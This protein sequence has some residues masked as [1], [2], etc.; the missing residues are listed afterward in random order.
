LSNEGISKEYSKTI[1]ELL[2]G[3]GLSYQLTKELAAIIDYTNYSNGKVANHLPD[4]K[5]DQVSLGL[6]YYF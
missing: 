3:A 4:F 1:T 2:L 5:L 6:K